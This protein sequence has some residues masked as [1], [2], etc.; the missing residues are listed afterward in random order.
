MNGRMDPGL[1]HA[2]APSR[3]RSHRTAG[4]EA[5]I[6]PLLVTLLGAGLLVALAGALAGN[7]PLAVAGAAPAGL[8]LVLLVGAGWIDLPTVVVLSIPL[9][10][11]YSSDS[12]RIAATAPLTALVLAGWILGVTIDR[13]RLRTAALPAGATL[14]LFASFL[15]A[16]VFARHPVTSLRELANFSLLLLLLVAVTDMFAR[17]EAAWPRALRLLVAVA[18]ACG[19]LAVLESAGVLPGRFPRAGS[20]LYRAALGFGQPNSLGLFLAIVLPLALH[21]V[22][23]ARTAAARAGWILA[24]TAVAAGLLATFSRGS[25]LAVLGGSA[26]LFFAGDRRLA[27]RVWAITLLV[28]LVVDVG[29]GGIL[30]DTAARTI[31]DWTVEQRFALMAAGILMFLT[32]P[33]TGVGPGGYADSLGEFGPLIPQ[34]WDYL[35]TPHNAFVQMAAETGIVGLAAFL[36]FLTIA[37]LR[38]LRSARAIGAQTPGPLA[39]RAGLLRAGLWSIAT[40]CATGMVAW[41]F[42]HGT[43]QAVVLMLAGAFVSSAQAQRMRQDPAAPEGRAIRL[44]RRPGATD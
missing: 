24:L 15:L 33:F 3:S 12:L 34:L 9:P 1:A 26:I 27:L 13:R 36:A 16:A 17:D 42:S 25:W 5:V 43:G 11:L 7:V 35:P 19:A 38:L 4:A 6:A 2:I 10:A 40:L 31:G 23:A 20:S 41:P 18:A 22:G 39:A 44:H 32:Y 37:M 30:R 14:T 21:P 28:A 8:A 29:S